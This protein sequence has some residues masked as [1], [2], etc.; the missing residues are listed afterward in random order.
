MDTKGQKRESASLGKIGKS[1]KE[2]IKSDGIGVGSFRLWINIGAAA[3]GFLFGGCH[4]LFGAYPLGLAL[5]CAMTTPV[6]PALFGAVLGSLT[7]GK[8]GMIY[9]MICTLGVFLRII[10]SGGADGNDDGEEAVLFSEPV[11]LRVSAALISGF[12]AAVYEILLSGIRLES[13][14]FGASMIALSSLMTFLFSGAFYHGVGVRALIFGSKRIF[15][16]PEDLSERQR[17]LF[18]KISALS[19]A[20]LISLALSRY[21]LFGISLSF[22]FSGCVTLFSAKR[23]GSLVGAGVGFFS[24]AIVSGI[25]SPAFA[26]L[27]IIAGALFPYGVRYA[28]TA[29][30]AA[31]SLWGSYMQGVSGFLSLL[32]EYLISLCIVVPMLNSFSRE[33]Y[34]GFAEDSEER[35][36]DMVGTMALAY[37]NR[38]QLACE[39]I[40]EGF[41][42]LIPLINAFL[43]SETTTEDF[44]AFLKIVTETKNYSL[45]SRE[46]DEELSAR[47]SDV[48]CSLGFKNSL[49]RVFGERRKYVICAVK[50]ADGTLITTPELKSEIERISGFSFSTPAYYRRKSMALME[51]EV[52]AKYKIKA[53]FFGEGGDGGEVSGDAVSFF[54]SSELYACGVIC[55]GMGSGDTAKRTADFT[56]GFLKALSSLGVSFDTVLH[57]INAVIRRQSEECSVGLDVFSFDM[58]TGEAEFIKSGAASSFVKRNA[59]LYRIKSETM[60]MGVIKRI[61]AEKIKVSVSEGDVIIM[62]SDGICEESSDAPWLVE[63]LNRDIGCGME[64]YA[65]GI[66]E[67]AKRYNKKRDDMS[68]LVM[69]IVKAE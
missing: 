64:E 68:V 49:I 48:P 38:E 51:C 9:A 54:E 66:I 67:T 31:L 63:Y 16:K 25:F 35:A 13:V 43:P 19:I 59:S 10:I 26:L 21:N 40:E 39:R 22:V 37:R 12:V 34:E 23:F 52:R 6:W 53:H 5:V 32:P 2:S 50:D 1:I 8:G 46:L 24:S 29:G 11:P 60:P 58:I 47:L 30:G 41:K 44:S 42:R 3:V 62:T 36:T 17:L 18:F 57:M 33:E 20:C 14:L 4:T 45:E 55:D 7:L 65:R 69:Q 27:G 15:S 61:D 56:I 28:L